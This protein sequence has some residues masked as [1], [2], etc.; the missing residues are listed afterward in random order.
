M[1]LTRFIWKTVLSAT[2]QDKEKNKK[3]CFAVAHTVLKKT[4]VENSAYLGRL[5]Y[6]D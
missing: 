6:A 1:F 4:W 2:F 3:K 5:V